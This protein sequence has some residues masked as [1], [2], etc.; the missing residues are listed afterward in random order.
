MKLYSDVGQNTDG[1]IT[2]KGISDALGTKVGA[3]YDAQ[4]E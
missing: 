3:S 2:Q 4:N 1:T